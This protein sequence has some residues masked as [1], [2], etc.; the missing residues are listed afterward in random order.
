V[1]ILNNTLYGNR[2]AALSIYGTGSE[3]KNVLVKNNIFVSESAN[4][5]TNDKNNATIT[6]E[7]NLYWPSRPK[8]VKITDSA[9]ITG[10]PRF[11]NPGKEDF[12]LLPGSAALDKGAATADVNADKDGRKRPGGA[13]SALGAFELKK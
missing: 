12:H 2:G 4:H 5:V 1:K 8:L 3:V 7:N 6:L 13:A 11:V 9:P 10:D